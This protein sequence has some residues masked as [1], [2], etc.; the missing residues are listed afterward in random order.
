MS[1]E[2]S[3]WHPLGRNGYNLNCCGPTGQ[4]LRFPVGTA[5][6]LRSSLYPQPVYLE[7]KSSPLLVST[8]WK[9]LQA[10]PQQAA[11]K[12]Q[13]HTHSSSCAFLYSPPSSSYSPRPSEQLNAIAGCSHDHLQIKQLYPTVPSLSIKHKWDN[14]SL[15]SQSFCPELLREKASS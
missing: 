12:S 11:L 5:K 7:N 15:R 8:C 10:P 6:P 2:L 1:K 13:F 4:R 9:K 3:T 14:G